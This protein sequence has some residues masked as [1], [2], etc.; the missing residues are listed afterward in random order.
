MTYIAVS[1]RVSVNDAQRRGIRSILA[2]WFGATQD[3][4]V[5]G[6]AYGV[7]TC[8]AVWALSEGIPVVLVVPQHLLWHRA[9]ASCEGCTVEYVDGGYMGRNEEIAER[10]DQ[11][12]AFPF[13]KREH[14]RS[15]T[16]ATVRRFEARMKPVTVRPLS[17]FK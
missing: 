2:S 13:T 14:L 1:G 10:S 7:D 5:T 9:L 6:G 4:L 15:G 11:L 8:A 16:W 3:T 12:L 17:A